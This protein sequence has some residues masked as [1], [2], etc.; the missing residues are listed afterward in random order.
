MTTTSTF[1]PPRGRSRIGRLQRAGRHAFRE[2]RTRRSNLRDL[3]NLSDHTLRDIGLHRSELTS[4]T[5]H[6]NDL[7]RR[8]RGSGRFFR[9]RSPF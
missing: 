4:I 1:A 9:L 3:Q 7:S 8:R 2:W 5:S 6:A